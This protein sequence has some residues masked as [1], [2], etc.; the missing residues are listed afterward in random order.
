MGGSM[1]GLNQKNNSG[2]RRARLIA[3]YLPQFHPIPE[4]DEWW[5]KGFTEWTNVTKAKPLFRGHHQPNLPADLGFY[6]LRV[7]EVREAQAQLAREHGIEGFCYWHYWF[8]NG[9]QLLERPFNEVLKSGKPDFPFC[10]GWAN[11]SWTGIWHGAAH[12]ILIQQTYPNEQD[13]KRHFF[14][15]LGAFQD[16]RYIRVENKPLFVVYRPEELPSPQR[17][18]HL[19]NELASKS[20]LPGIYFLGIFGNPPRVQPQ[21]FGFD[22]KTGHFPGAIFAR[23]KRPFPT[24]MK[25]LTGAPARFYYKDYINE[26]RTIFKE[27]PEMYP[28]VVPNWDNTPRSAENGVVLLE[29]EPKLF[30]I[31]LKDALQTVSDLPFDRK[32]VFLKSWNEWA[33]GNYLEPDQIYGKAYLEEI[34]AAIY[35]K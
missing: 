22:G 27:N 12:R 3:F 33:E 29:N 35:K 32:I 2:E 16:P 17:F 13:E 34:K 28:C 4:N 26:A 31:H 24:F 8:G 7:P 5:G 9:K 21:D 10:L 14:E 6:D 25:K 19:W 18:T 11:E 15:I 20:G 30:S 23:L 1:I